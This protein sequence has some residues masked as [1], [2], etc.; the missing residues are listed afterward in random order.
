MTT[1]AS[2]SIA[3]WHTLL[4][5]QFVAT[6]FIGLLLL[7][8]LSNRFKRDLSS[9]PGPT[10]A[11]YTRLWRLYDAWTGETHSVSIR[12]HRKYGD[13]VRIGPKHVTFSH[14]NAIADIYGPT[15]A[16]SKTGFYSVQ[17]SLL[18]NKVTE[19]LFSTRDASFHRNQKK[20]IANAYSMT[21]VLGMEDQIDS[22]ITLLLSQLKG[23]SRK[24]ET[25]D[26]GQWVQFFAFDATG[27][28]SFSKKLGFLREGRDFDGIINT[29]ASQ[30]SYGNIIGQIPELNHLLFGN[31]FF[32]MLFPQMENRNHIMQFTM[33]AVDT[34]LATSGTTTMSEQE[35]AD[36]GEPKGK[37]QD[38][39]SRWWAIH[40][41]DPDK[42]SR[43]DL[44]LQLSLNVMAGSDTQAIS[45]RSTLNNMM[46]NPVKL[47]KARQEV[48]DA[49]AAG[50]LSGSITYNEVTTHLPYV[51]A[52]IKEGLRLH[53]AV[54]QP[55]ERHVPAGG[56]IIC[57]KYYPEGTVVG[58]NAWASQRHPEFFQD[59]DEFIPERWLESS[60]AQL[61]DME[62]A[63]LYFGAGSRTCIGKNVALSGMHKLMAH[64]LR[65]FDMKLH[66]PNKPLDIVCKGLVLQEGL[67]VDLEERKP[68]AKF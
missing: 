39:L 50:K 30:L 15:K 67:L 20:V 18:D 31:R 27:E 21:S 29:I 41:K 56:A 51:C 36:R 63:L 13:V 52:C 42:L 61:K 40:E 58:V 10:L 66:N 62:R 68:S 57:G 4:R 1:L 53:P 7:R 43:R 64:L 49:E 59:P 3:F 24:K 65:E 17:S 48:D 45:L 37:D 33:K 55:L 2:I 12:L 38:M 26:L 44:I 5:A 32:R 28:V 14:P 60:P 35:S 23:K 46:H 47:I 34:K 11:K 25:V 54:G 9:I 22:C 6:I 16:F 8:L 19:N